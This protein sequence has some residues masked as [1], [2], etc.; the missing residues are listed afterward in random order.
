LPPCRFD[1]LLIVAAKF[2]LHILRLQ[3]ESFDSAT[4]DSAFALHHKRK[5]HEEQISSFAQI[6]K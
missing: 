3:Q 4:R 2:A 6:A 5:E 1:F